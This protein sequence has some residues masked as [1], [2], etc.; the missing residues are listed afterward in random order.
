MKGKNVGKVRKPRA[1]TSGTETSVIAPALGHGQQE[2][3]F[4]QAKMYPEMLIRVGHEFSG[5]KIP[6]DITPRGRHFISECRCPCA[7][8]IT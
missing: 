2:A 5:L 8:P 3:I 1:V 6:G 4:R 7:Y